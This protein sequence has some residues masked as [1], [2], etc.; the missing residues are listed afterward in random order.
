MMYFLFLFVFFLTVTVYRC[1]VMAR[2]CSTCLSLRES[3]ATAHY[4]CQWCGDTCVFNG[5]CFD[6]DGSEIAAT[7]YCPLAHIA[8][9]S[10]HLDFNVMDSKTPEYCSDLVSV[11]FQPVRWSGVTKIG[12]CQLPW[13]LHSASLC[14]R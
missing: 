4:S 13:K 12:S 10:S 6:V 8:H 1:D 14:Y 2:D 5:S 3:P 11:V 9:V 7:N